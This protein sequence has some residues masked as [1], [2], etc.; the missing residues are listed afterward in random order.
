M[1]K[2]NGQEE[3][4]Q[5]GGQLRHPRARARRPFRGQF[6]L[7]SDRLHRSKWQPIPLQVFVDQK[8]LCEYEYRVPLSTVTYLRIVGDLSLS[9]VNWEGQYYVCYLAIGFYVGSPIG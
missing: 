5:G 7:G 3:P 9:S 8:E 6:R 1:G 4:L 2:R